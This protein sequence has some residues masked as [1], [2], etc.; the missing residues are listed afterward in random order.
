MNTK[1]NRRAQETV[2]RIVRAVYSFI[3]AEKRPVSKITVRE[4][5]ERAQINRSTFY[6]HFLDVYDVVES[7]DQ[8]M[9]E[10]INDA[11]MGNMGSDNFLRDG[12][13]TMFRF[14]QEYRQ[15]YLIFF[16]E[17]RR[18]HAIELL[19]NLQQERLRQIRPE[20]FGCETQAELNYCQEYFAAG[21]VALIYQ[22][23]KNDCR[24]TPETLYRLL[25]R[26]C[27]Q[28]WP[29]GAFT[30]PESKMEESAAASSAR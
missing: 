25:R 12:F 4:V 27:G 15:F 17:S 28:G 29:F 21:V 23:L 19:T 2:E 1:N 22:W 10:R 16:E 14:I 26:Q 13:T 8:T 7:V 5:C 3:A 6:A 20:D 18:S 11:M 24:E 30:P 9:V